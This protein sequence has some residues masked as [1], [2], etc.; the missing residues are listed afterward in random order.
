MIQV[1][2]RAVAILEYLAE[3][4]EQPRRLKDLAG[5]MRLNTATCANI[6]KTLRE[7]GLVAKNDAGYQLGPW[8]DHMGQK[9]PYR[10]RLAIAEPEIVRLANEVGETVLLAVI[11]QGRRYVLCH[12]DGNRT[13]QVRP[14]FL[15]RENLYQSASGR[16]LLAYLAEDEIKAIVQ[17]QGLPG[18]NWPEI[19]STAQLQRVLQQIR[20]RRF[21]V[22]QDQEFAHIVRQIRGIAGP[23][24]QGG[25]VVAAVAMLVPAL[26]FQGAERRRL[27]RAVQ[28]AAA[29]ISKMV[30]SLPGGMSAARTEP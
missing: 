12:A 8:I 4:P 17:Q 23:V 30:S 27:I 24:W 5:R 1:I 7:R 15:F 22:R 29:R 3:K 19:N 20:R 21:V 2:H 13:M 26:R 28:D 14:D 9:S 11:H 6:L 25:A 18:K 10:Q 16:L